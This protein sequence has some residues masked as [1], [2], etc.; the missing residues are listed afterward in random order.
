MNRESPKLSKLKYEF[1]TCR[2]ASTFH[3]NGELMYSPVQSVRFT[4]SGLVLSVQ[5]SMRPLKRLRPY[6]ANGISKLNETNAA[7][8]GY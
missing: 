3:V 1:V 2:G 7:C 5:C 6:K 8:N 4:I